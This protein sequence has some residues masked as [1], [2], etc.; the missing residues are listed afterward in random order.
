DAG[1]PVEAHAAALRATGLFGRVA[2][3]L[4]AGGPPPAEIL[5]SC[6]GPRVDVV[7][8]FMEAGWFTAVAVPRALQLD[9]QVPPERSVRIVEPV[10]THPALAAVI[11]ARVARHAPE[12]RRL[13]L[14]GH[15]SARRPGRRLALHDHADRLASLFERVEVALLEE[16]PFVPDA[17]A[18]LRGAP[19]A[20]LGL[21]LGAGGH[22]REDVPA[23]LAAAAADGALRDCGTIA[24]EPGLRSI[25][26]DRVG[27]ATDRVA[28]VPLEWP[29]GTPNTRRMEE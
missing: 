23:L 17:L 8:F 28:G 18:R 6:P 15:G 9:G 4:L 25:V 19:V 24:E 1:A 20:T 11:A 12:A 21:F 10:G 5:A 14:I 29:A 26:L 22:V 27:L 3:A 16:P 13:L 7:P 2:V